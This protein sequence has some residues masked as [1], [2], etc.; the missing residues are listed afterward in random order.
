MRVSLLP[1]LSRALSVLVLALFGFARSAYGDINTINQQVW[2]SKFAVS[3]AQLY[4]GGDP[5]Q[6]LNATWLDADDD[7]D[8]VKNKDELAGGTNPFSRLNTIKI[9]DIST[10]GGNVTITFPTEDGKRYRAQSTTTLANPASWSFPA[11]TPLVGTGSPGQIVRPYVANT[12]FRVVV[13]DNDTSGSGVS[14]WAKKIVGYNINTTMTDGHTPD[15]A[16]IFAALASLNKVTVTVNKANATQ[17]ADALTAPVEV[18]SVTVSRGIAKLGSLTAKTPIT[19]PL[20]KVGTATEG[21]DYD[22]I[23]SSVTFNTVGSPTPQPVTSQTFSINPKFNSSRKT[24]V[25]AI[26]KAVAG[27]DYTLGSANSASVVINPAGIANGSGLTG[28][29][30]NTS[31][32]TYSPNQTN[33]FAGAAQMT[34]IDPVLDFGTSALSPA[35][36]IASIAVGNP[37]VVTTTRATS[38]STGDSVTIAGVTGGTFSPSINGTFVVTV[39]SGTTFTVPVDCQALPTAVTS[40]TLT[41]ASTTNFNGWGTANGGPRGMS[42]V[43]ATTAFSVRWTGQILPQYSERYSIDFR[44]DDS[45]KVWVNGLP[46]IDR[47]TAQGATDYVNSIDLTAGVPYDIVIEYFNSSSG[48]E[49]RL[50]WW[51]PSQPKQIIPQ[52]RL[53]PALAL[54]QKMTML[55][56][57]LTAV[58]YE[59]VPFTFSVVTP[60]ISGTVTYALDANSAPLPPGL[61]LAASGAITGT[62]TLAG[63]YNVA[64]NAINAAANSGAGAVTGSSIVTFT[65]YPT[66]SVTREKDLAAN[67]TFTADGT[68]TTVDDDTNYG[69]A[70]TR[71]L[72][73]Y[74]VPP[75]TGN[76]YFWLAANNSAEL[77]ISN[78]AQYVNRVRRA[79]GT[80]NTGKKIWS[81]F[82]SQKTQWL[83]L[84]AGQKYYFDVLHYAPGGGVD[85]YVA[86]GWCQDDIGTV[87][88]TT[89]SP[90]PTGVTPQI[91]NGGAALDGYPF[92][93]GVPSYIFQPYDY[94]ALVATGG[95]LYSANLGPQAG[96]ATQASGSANLRVNAAGTQAILY[97]SYQNLTTPKT[98]YHLHVDG[99][100]DAGNVIHPQGEIVYDIDSAELEPDLR[101]S[102]GGLIWDFA[103]LGSFL[104]G[105]SDTL[106]DALKKGKV[107]LNVHSVQFPSGEIR[108]NLTLVDGSQTPPDPGLYPPRSMNDLAS[109]ATGAAAA[110]FLNQA[111]FGASPADIAYVKANG[112][113]A[114]IDKHVD[115]L[116]PL[117]PPTSHTSGDVVNNITADINAPYPSALFTNAWWKYSITGSDQLRQRLAFALSE[118]MVV[119]WANDTGPLQNNGRIVADYYDQLVD[120]C[121]PTPGLADSGNFR[122]I[123][124]AVTLTPAM[125]LYLDMRGNQKGDDSLGR[126]PNENYAR[127]IMQLFSVG[128]NRMW[129]D[130]KFVLDSDANLVP[131][132]AQPSIL[133]MSALL[134]GWNYAQANQANGRAPTNFGPAA[135]YLNPM[136]LVPTQHDFYAKLLLDNV[137]TPPATGVTPRVSIASIAV[138]NPCRVTTATVHGLK[139]GDT[140]TIAGVSGGAFSGGGIN[141][142]FQVTV[143]GT[144]TFTI[145]I[146]CSIAPSNATGTVTGATVLSPTFTTSGITAVTGSQADN[147]GTA[148]PHPYDQYG[149][150]E[151]D[152]AIDNIVNNDN[153][154]PYICRQLIQRLVTSDPSPGYIYRVVQKFKNNGS[155]VRGDLVA[156][157]KQI[158][159]DG[160][161]RGN[162]EVPNNFGKQ[163]E[164]ML[165]LTG[166]A[167]AFPGTSYTGTYQQLTGLNANKLRIITSTPN[168]FNSGFSVSLDFRGNYTQTSPPNPYGNPTSTTY[169][170]GTTTA[171]AATHLDVTSISTSLVGGTATTITCAQPHGLGPNGQTRSV[172][173]LGLSGKFSDASINSGAKTAT[174]TGP[175][176]FTVTPTTN[177]VFQVAS[178]AIS[179]PCIVTTVAPHGLPAGATTGVTIN[180]ITGG[181]FSGGATSINGTTFT[182]TNTS[183]NTFTVASSGGTPVNCTAVPTSYTTWRQCSNPCRVTTVTPHGLANGDIVTI[184]SVSG[185]SFSTT[186]PTGTTIN[187]TWAVSEVDPTAPAAFTL[188]TVNCV[189]PSTANTGNIVG[190]STM[191]I[192]A[193]GMVTATYTQTAGSSTMT[194]NTAGPQTDVAIPS[195]TTG[196]TTLKSKV[197]LAVLSRNASL[198]LTSMAI[199]TDPVQITKASH[200]LVTGDVVTIGGVTGGSF[201]GG[202]NNINRTHTVTVIDA[203]TFTVP[204][205]LGGTA[206]TTPGTATGAFGPVATDGEYLVQTNGSNLFTITTAD[207]PTATR[208]GSVLM[209]KFTTSYSPLSNN[210][211]VQFNTNVNHNMLVGQRVWVDVPVITTPLTDSEYT[212]TAT[213]DEDHFTTSYLPVSSSLGVYPKPSGSNNGITVFPL[214]HPPG[215]APLTP[216]SGNVSINQS[217]FNVGTTEATLTQSPLNAPTVFNYFL[218]DYKFPGDLSNKGLDSPEFQL[219]TDTNVMNLTNSLTNVFIGTG[220]GNGNLNG[221][222]SFN[223]GGGSVVL[224]IG[225]TNPALAPVYMIAAKTS[226]AGVPALIDE[227]AYL[228]VGGPLVPAT[229]TEI[230][231]FVANTGNFPYTSPVPTNQQMR[232]RVR[233]II[234]LII[235]SAEY[236]VQK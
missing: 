224:D 66:G 152:I 220:G 157:V 86:M 58:G 129:D 22:S 44:S 69:T 40:A 42:P 223:N 100:T 216:R 228:L 93:G 76:Y 200:G 98:N 47:W 196:T 192:T 126:H 116:N 36:M 103:A 231:N 83:A 151:L 35:P 29:Y 170:I 187:G 89:A 94:P 99:Y 145:P 4:T 8:G 110:R 166:P 92:S 185:G 194:V 28:K 6:G 232:D 167:R 130:G 164:P 31:S 33:I 87:A 227:L 18:G 115:P 142:I 54:D 26:V 65:I 32:A 203:N 52:S 155:G 85:D 178:V 102:D 205:P 96:A 173:F 206:P 198:P 67:G 221:L 113:T 61:S 177:Y 163:R 182:V 23:P 101:T 16:A 193:T 207:V 20:Q 68:I 141:A 112:F 183:P 104:N 41:P 11:Q 124:K 107:Y 56:H 168:D 57:S 156:V 25:T 50:Y 139:T 225:N 78:D 49:A 144:T 55:T 140:V 88:S 136:V 5:A 215:V 77:W 81:V 2:Q 14:D 80:G 118:I 197:Y 79:T 235:T 95:T 174:V 84:K 27:A 209:P 53:F 125:G 106:L 119:S 121:L 189:S 59:N 120:Y 179:N 46:L 10:S 74:I 132:Y 21:T 146:I 137:V 62:P 218:P 43:S 233:A 158:L 135:D 201:T 165:R 37:C 138:L 236:A 154:P 71:R 171:I 211:I 91:P 63:T 188:A 17:P 134:T 181:T 147:S 13:D 109:D 213:A 60:N 131:T 148:S 3:N 208:T 7:G 161:A 64:I 191:E 108:G 75:K 169:S 217:T 150:K 19:V 222:S 149:L 72:R 105:G 97:L 82:A 123:L 34:R 202:V 12:F 153:V 122:G 162:P 180:G 210:T 234:H 128:L 114:W 127:E 9:T 45:A 175:N 51:S 143:T 199:N 212:L 230:Q 111:T 176:T 219:T 117:Y 184:S 38:L 214:A 70:T 195:P 226:N 133:G 229:R 24:N 186:S 172:W 15:A 73:G 48:A 190:S 204:V 90:N 1:A 159:L 160:E 39:T 30:F